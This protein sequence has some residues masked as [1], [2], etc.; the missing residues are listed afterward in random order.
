MKNVELKIRALAAQGDPA[1]IEAVEFMEKLI[2]LDDEDKETILFLAK[3]KIVL[4]NP[5]YNWLCFFEKII[6]RTNKNSLPI[7]EI[8]VLRE[9][10][11]DILDQI[12]VKNKKGEIFQVKKWKGKFFHNKKGYWEEYE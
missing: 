12:T 2:M 9:L 5:Y 8:G 6:S 1:A 4:E 7:H 3:N 11:K 10:E